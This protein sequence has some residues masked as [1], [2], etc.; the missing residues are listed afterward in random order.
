MSAIQSSLQ[1]YNRSIAQVG[2]AKKQLQTIS[3]AKD[4]GSLMTEIGTASGVVSGIGKKFKVDV[5]KP[6]RTAGDKLQSIGTKIR[7]NANI[8]SRGYS[9]ADIASTSAA[10][11]AVGSGVADVASADLTATA[12]GG[13]GLEALGGL[14]AVAPELVGLG[15]AGY[16]A[17]EGIKG[18]W[19]EYHK[20]VANQATGTEGAEG[21]FESKEATQTKDS[22]NLIG[23]IA[24]Q[25][26]GAAQTIHGGASAITPLG[27]GASS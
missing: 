22:S 25:Q 3:K 17:Y 7:T 10:D 11:D 21:N 5:A 15:L 19:D 2:Q 24:T 13:A 16:G 6:V 18:W 23:Q 14:T 26:R 27:S 12:V 9:D 20:G 4:K 1:N 8:K